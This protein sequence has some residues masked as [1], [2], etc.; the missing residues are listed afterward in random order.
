MRRRAVTAADFGEYRRQGRAEASAGKLI[1]Q[2]HWE[3][4]T[5]FRHNFSKMNANS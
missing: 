3:Y 2:T 1:T 4:L 5:C